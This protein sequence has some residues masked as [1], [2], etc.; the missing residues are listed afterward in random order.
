MVPPSKKKPMDLTDISGFTKGGDY[1]KTVHLRAADGMRASILTLGARL[2]DL[3]LAD[4]RPLALSLATLDEVEADPAYVGVAVG[5]TAN[6]I[7]AGTLRRNG[8]FADVALECNEGRNHTHGGRRAWDKRLFAVT[9]LSQA[10]A[11]LFLY[12]PDGDQGYPSSVEVTVRYELTGRGE[13][14]VSLVTRNV[15]FERT[16]TNMTVCA[17]FSLFFQGCSNAGCFPG[18]I[19]NFTPSQCSFAKYPLNWNCVRR[20]CTL[21]LTLKGTADGLGIACTIMRLWRHHPRTT[22]S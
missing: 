16:L 12:S 19:A 17:A 10:A 21:I 14:V 18:R 9:H 2:L 20:S 7:R 1:A 6:R 13:L 3:R 8:D 5:R 15:G 4:G 11:E 22:W